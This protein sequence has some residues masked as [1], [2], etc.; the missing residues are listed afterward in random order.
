[1]T[2]K[3]SQKMIVSILTLLTLTLS[4]PA[5][6][7]GF[8]GG[9]HEALGPRYNATPLGRVAPRPSLQREDDIRD[10]IRHWNE[11]AVNMSGLDH[12]P[13]AP[14]ENRVFGEQ[15]GPLL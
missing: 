13:V 15:Y 11:V 2:A 12:T 9:V 4:L 6:A 1:M 3:Q 5:W 7:G 8:S 14:G 10:R